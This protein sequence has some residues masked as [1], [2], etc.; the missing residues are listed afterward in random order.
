M[1]RSWR[2]AAALA[3]LAGCIPVTVNLNFNF[4]QKEMEEKL[5][6]MEKMVEAE[7][8]NLPP[9]GPDQGNAAAFDPVQEG[10][11]DINVDTP[12]IEKINESRKKRVNAL[13]GHFKAGRL[14]ET[15]KGLLALRSDE[16]LAGKEKAELAKVLNGENGDRGALFKEILK[17]N[18]LTEEQLDNVRTAFA[19]A[20]YRALETG[21]WLQ[22]QKGEW[23]QKT[24]EDQKKLDK[25][26]D[27]D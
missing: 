15:R 11:I 4:P 8:M 12:A 23:R 21:R 1:T 13:A 2:F 22:S 20:R 7:G 25:G 14:G 17:A 18:K 27:V 9:G 5:F 19:M 26:E 3:L 6:E 24:D 16:G 10:K